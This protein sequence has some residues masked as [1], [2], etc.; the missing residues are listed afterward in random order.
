MNI[1]LR[2]K[3]LLAK[4]VLTE[5]MWH[6]N[7]TILM[8]HRVAGI[9]PDP[10]L[11]D[12]SPGNFY[13]QVQ[14]L[15]KY[16][17][18]S[19]RQFVANLEAGKLSRSLVITFDD[20]YR[21]NFINAIPVLT[22]AGLPATFFIAS[23]YTGTQKELWTN[24]LE[25]ILLSPGELPENIEINT[26]GIRFSH[27][28][29]DDR[30]VTE[31]RMEQYQNWISWEAPPTQRHSLYMG[32]A[33]L[34]RPLRTEQQD[35]ILKLL[36]QWA[37]KKQ[38]VSLCNLMMD[39]EELK[40]ISAHPLFEIGAHTVSHTALSFLSA[41]DQYKEIKGNMTFLEKII[42]KPVQGMAYPYGSYNTDTILE[43]TRAGLNYACTTQY[44]PV[45]R[46]DSSLRLP[47]FRV[48]DWTGREFKKI[49]DRWI[50]FGI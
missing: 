20:G 4:K 21:D 25:R 37:G 49:I 11:L 50:R 14:V 40:K 22:A 35:E 30:L 27:H 47:R 2:N 17:V 1:Q 46:H 36:Y 6:S 18:I 23:G 5:G 38:V 26:Q 3:A 12:V 43:A 42:Q 28:L 24:D 10:W 16:P 33:K 29:G 48:R 41:A 9:K 32:I 7:A 19:L 8:Y 31:S 15:K 13:E 34:M 44:S 45:S 39:E